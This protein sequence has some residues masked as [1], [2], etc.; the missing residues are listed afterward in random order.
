MKIKKI[1]SIIIMSICTMVLY[2]YSSEEKEE[3]VKRIEE[4]GSTTAISLIVP[5][6]PQI[7][8]VEI[9]WYPQLLEA[10]IIYKVSYKE[11]RK[12]TAAEILRDYSIWMTTTYGVPIV[13]IQY[14]T[15]YSGDPNKDD[16][17]EYK[18][19]EDSKEVWYT[20]HILIY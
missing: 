20:R 14:R 5:N 6:Q 13:K 8:K 12:S 9:I 2:S 7:G 15:L 1:F 11:R 3:I 16:K 10:R 19:L 4:Y 18:S 17:E